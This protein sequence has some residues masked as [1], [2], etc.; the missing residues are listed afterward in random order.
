MGIP[1]GLLAVATVGYIVFRIRRMRK[2][3]TAA[4]A[5]R[6][7]QE[8][9]AQHYSQASSGLIVNNNAKWYQQPNPG[10]KPAEMGVGE[11]DRVPY[12]LG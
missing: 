5:E 7:Q 4:E 6:Q 10:G 9:Y 8:R 11:N 2:K 3:D 1:L 12:E